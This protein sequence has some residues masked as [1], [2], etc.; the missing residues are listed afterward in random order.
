MNRTEGECMDRNTMIG[1]AGAVIGIAVAAAVGI[2]FLFFFKPVE[3]QRYEA[4]VTLN[5][6]GDMHVREEWHMRYNVTNYR[7]RFRDIDY[8]KYGEGYD[9]PM[10]EA[11][12]ASF[13]E[14]AA[15][16]TVFKN[17]VDIT[18]ELRIGFSF[19]NDRDELGD[20]VRCEPIRS[21]CE[22]I[23]VD[24]RQEGNLRGDFIFVYEFTITGAV[25]EYSDISELNWR[26]FEYMEGT[27]EE[28]TVTIHLP[29]N[30]SGDD[31]LHIWGHGIGEGLIHT[32]DPAGNT[33]E[34]SIQNVN[35][36]EFLEFRLLAER[37]RFPDIA[38]NNVFIHEDMNQQVIMDYQAEQIRWGNIQYYVL[39]IV[40]GISI[41]AAV[42]MVPVFI[43]VYRRYFKRPETAF[44]GDYMRE[45]PS[46]HT[47]GEMSY[48]YHFKKTNNEDVTAT[49][50]D[51][52]RR[53]HVH[54]EFAGTDLTSK[55]ADFTLTRVE[56]APDETLL[57]HEDHILKWFFDVIG[58]GK[59][60]KTKTIENFGKKSLANAERF[61]K[62]AKTFVAMIKRHVEEQ[63]RATSAPSTR[64]THY[65]FFDADLPSKKKKAAAFAA[66]PISALVI[67]LLTALFF[68]INNL[69]ACIIAGV[70]AAVYLV[71]VFIQRRRSAPGTE[72]FKK[73]DAFKRFLLDFGEFKDYPMPGVSVWEHYLVYGTSLKVADQV[74]KQLQVKL[75][76]TD[77]VARDSRY[78]GVGYR[79]RGFAYGAGIMSFNRS[80]NTAQR[81]VARKISASKSS[82]R[83]GGFGGGSSRGGGGGGGRSR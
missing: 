57:P 16:V 11:N 37:E 13:D 55:D 60:V 74:M 39:R 44:D 49:L 50:L 68:N 47:P 15:S 52:I 78:L 41:V 1:I 27:I 30:V 24:T 17:G 31:D 22:S 6:S 72:L 12:T 28:G 48:M 36:G 45:L 69:Y 83:G 35:R 8:N 62:E 7:V 21:Q 40:L 38:A 29:D 26:L 61:Q 71:F 10:S 5:E 23:F 54:L 2:F 32:F 33:I 42:A 25:T 51:L 20:P 77:D 19:N 64:S 18:D 56:D 59:T 67:A 79:T 65:D 9:L 34:M 73:W 53:K 80:I 58:D 82:S 14:N 70:S 3:I 66:I 63:S 43:H 75:P 81:N 76:M 46:A 4:V